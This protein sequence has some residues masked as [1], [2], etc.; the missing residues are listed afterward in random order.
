M[1]GLS[2]QC[3]DLRAMDAYMGAVASSEGTP[4]ALSLCFAPNL[5]LK[6]PRPFTSMLHPSLPNSAGLR[7]HPSS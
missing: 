1:T 6:D 2:V 3:G 4:A 7:H 5:V